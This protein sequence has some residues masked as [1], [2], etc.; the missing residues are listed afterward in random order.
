V[1]KL[2]ELGKR[3]LVVVPGAYVTDGKVPNSV[4][5]SQRIAT[6][7]PEDHVSSNYLCAC[8]RC[9]CRVH[10]TVYCSGCQCNSLVLYL[11][12]LS[13]VGLCRRYRR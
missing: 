12:F 8:M 4:H 10:C 7:T 6:L 1:D 13:N 5:R 11:L 3:A 9:R 2:A